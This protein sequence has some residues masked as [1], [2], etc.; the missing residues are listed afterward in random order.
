M[1]FIDAKELREKGSIALLQNGAVIKAID[2]EMLKVLDDVEDTATDAKEKRKIKVEFT[3][4]SNISRKSISLEADVST[5]LAKKKVMQMGL[6]IEKAITDEGMM[7]T[8]KEEME[9]AE[10]QQNIDGE[11]NQSESITYDVPEKDNVVDAEFIEKES[12]TEESIHNDIETREVVENDTTDLES[13]SE[14]ILTEEE[15]NDLPFGKENYE[16]EDDQEFP[17]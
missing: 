12:H 1:L 6:A 13:S 17:F 3:I 2:K 8:M 9:E 11:E 7:I 15:I 4:T 16:S 10:G 14:S 5:V